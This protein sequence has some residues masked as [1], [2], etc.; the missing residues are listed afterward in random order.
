MKLAG[1][2]SVSTPQYKLE[3]EVINHDLFL[4]GKDIEKEIL[5]NQHANVQR[6]VFSQEF[7][8]VALSLALK[9]SQKS[10]NNP[11]IFVCW[12]F[13]VVLA[14]PQTLEVFLS[15]AWPSLTFVGNVGK[16]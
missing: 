4:K 16:Y 1:C 2:I 3:L 5:T 12:Y 8:L 15:R 9:L 10:E 14:S 13:Q 6:V 11:T 7:L